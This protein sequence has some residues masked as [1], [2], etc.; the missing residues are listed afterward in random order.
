MFYIVLNSKGGVGKTTTISNVLSGYIHKKNNTKVKIFEV[1]DNNESGNALKGSEIVEY[2]S[3]SVNAGIE[4]IN[5]ALFDVFSGEDILIDAGG[6]NDTNNLIKAIG[7]LGVASECVFC[8]P[9]LKNRAGMKNVKRTY[10]KIR[11]ISK[12]AKIVFIFNQ[13]RSL[14]ADDIMSEFVYFFGNPKMKID[15]IAEDILDAN[16]ATI[17]VADTNVFDFA[18]EYEMTAY[19]IG[20]EQINPKEFYE[21]EKSKGKD[22]MIKAGAF[23]QIYSKCKAFKDECLIP[24]YKELD[25]FL[26]E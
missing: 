9:F 11:A 10:E 12:D 18:E 14:K 8:I 19:E 20:K 15:G 17:A 21:T 22:A 13:C 24:A 7:E 6:G 1:D 25:E 5:E 26:K 23:M 4:Q 16:T 2:K 3:F